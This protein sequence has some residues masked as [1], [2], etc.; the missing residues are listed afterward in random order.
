MIVRFFF[1]RVYK[2]ILRKNHAV[3]I[4]LSF[5]VISWAG[6]GE[7]RNLKLIL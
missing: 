7:N 2:E 3:P 6:V 1:V 5:I 4:A